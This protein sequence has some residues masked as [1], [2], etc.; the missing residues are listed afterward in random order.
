MRRSLPDWC[1]NNRILDWEEQNMWRLVTIDLLV[2]FCFFKP[3]D[4]RKRGLLVKTRGKMRIY[5]HKIQRYGALRMTTI[6]ISRPQVKHCRIVFP[7]SSKWRELESRQSFFFFFSYNQAQLSP[8]AK[9][10]FSNDPAWFWAVSEEFWLEM[11]LLL[12]FKAVSSK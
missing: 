3:V 4:V 10:M 9:I 11:R 5:S 7:R 12:A 1:L 6:S 8:G 2:D